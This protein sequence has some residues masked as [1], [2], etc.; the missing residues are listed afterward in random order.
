M[1]PFFVK[2]V[3]GEDRHRATFR[4]ESAED[5]AK[6]DAQVID[7]KKH[8]QR[9]NEDHDPE[10]HD[11]LYVGWIMKVKGFHY[12]WGSTRVPLDIKDSLNTVEEGC[13]IQVTKW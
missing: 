9:I 7:I 1:P 2:Y 10:D 12:E 4:F 11:P 8:I 5:V 3:T 6:W 13:G